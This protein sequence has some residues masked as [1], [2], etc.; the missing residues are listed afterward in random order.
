MKLF[1]TSSQAVGNVTIVHIG[2]IE[3]TACHNK[4]DKENVYTF[5]KTDGDNRR[6]L[7]EY[8]EEL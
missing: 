3:I 2:S 4:L 7:S 5:Y 1:E 8:R 6:Y